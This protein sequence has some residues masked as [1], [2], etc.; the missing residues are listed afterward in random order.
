MNYNKLNNNNNFALQKEIDKLNKDIEILV[1]K[2]SIYEQRIN[3]MNIKYNNTFKL[4]EEQK[5]TINQLNKEIINYIKKEKKNEETN[6]NYIKQIEDLNNSI[7]STNKVIIQ[8]DELINQLK[9]RKMLIN[10]NNNSDE[11]NANFNYNEIS[12][13]KLENEN[14]KKEIEE[15]KLQ[16][17]KHNNYNNSS[18]KKDIIMDKDINELQALNIKLLEENNTIKNKNKELLEKIK[19][20]TLEN[21]KIK[22]SF[23]SQ[24]E[25]ISKLEKDIINKNEE[26]EGLKIVIFKLQSQL[27]TKDDN[28]ALLKKK[29][30]N[31]EK[32]SCAN[33]NELNKSNDIIKKKNSN[34]DNKS[35]D[36]TKEGSNTTIKNLLNKLNDAEKTINNLQNKNKELLSKLE[37]KEIQKDISGFRTEDNNISNYEEEFDL[38]RMVSGA[39]DK[40]RSEDIN[41][42]YPGVQGIKDKYKELLQNKNM[43]EDLIKTLFFNLNCNNSK[44]KPQIK[45]I[46]QLMGISAKNIELIIAG[47]DKKRAL[48]LFD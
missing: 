13:M 18:L 15:I 46:C 36:G 16:N 24:K 14:L 47:K 40:N 7:L 20:L 29:S 39:R 4:C 5:I 3:N 41:I 35:F 6:N 28:L 37:E 32:G 45:Q 12:Q 42:D 10:Y 9:D 31:M 19:E 8:K 11:I 27:E 38:K 33:L 26:L 23:T 21:N 1:N 22:E 17:D 25:S 43:I 44:I 34:L 30:K 48:G 2:N